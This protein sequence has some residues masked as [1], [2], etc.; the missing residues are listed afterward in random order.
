MWLN[1]PLWSM[2]GLFVSWDLAK[3]W[4]APY[5]GGLP[6]RNVSGC[7][8]GPCSRVGI[9][10]HSLLPV[11]IST[12]PS[13][14]FICSCPS[15]GLTAEDGHLLPS[16]PQAMEPTLPAPLC[17][18]AH[19]PGSVYTSS[20]S[21]PLR[22][23]CASCP[24][25]SAAQRVWWMRMEAVLRACAHAHEASALDEHQEPSTTR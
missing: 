15:P 21:N 19:P 4:A 13:C 6:G 22:T 9:G 3:A 1:R 25:T 18:Q 17:R 20:L 24:S 23:N 11:P 7:L 16:R 12:V 10:Q 8:E 2:P 14:L 5:Q